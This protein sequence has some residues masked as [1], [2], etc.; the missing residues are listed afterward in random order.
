MIVNLPV[1]DRILR[2]RSFI[3]P[4]KHV[5]SRDNRLPSGTM[6][7]RENPMIEGSSTEQT[8]LAFDAA[9][10]VYD[11]AS[12]HLQGIQRM[13]STTSRLYLQY[14]PRG[15]R[16][17]EINCGTGNDA[18]TLAKHG[19][20]ILAT[21]LSSSMLE[22]TQ[23]KI[24]AEALQLSIQT[25]Q[26]S[27]D[28]LGELR[29]DVFDGAYSNLGGINCA[30]SLPSLAADLGALVKPGGFFIATVMPP[31][32]LWESASFLFRF[33][34][35]QAFRRQ[36]RYGTLANLHGGEVRTYY[37]SPRA[38]RGIFAPFFD[39]VM[40]LGM[41]VFTPPPNFTRA[42]ATIRSGLRLLEALDDV[43]AGIPPFRSIGD[44]YVIVLR[45]TAR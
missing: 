5:S 35:R 40:T 28:H 44:H 4:L 41:A 9:A 29:G 16:L 27:F 43:L 20:S 36:S 32:C 17:L 7:P 2:R 45:R 3:L 22:E 24:R 11:A 31:F 33:Q 14:F 12:E 6:P 37:H 1:R 18:I 8:R 39:H 21:D 38:F 30:D 15:S 34:I 42:Y 19:M 23:K 26:L 13:R 10:P 25:K